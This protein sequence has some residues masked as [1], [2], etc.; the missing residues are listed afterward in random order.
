MNRRLLIFLVAIPALIVVYLAVHGLPW[1]DASEPPESQPPPR[2]GKAKPVAKGEK[3]AKALW[4]A[5]SQGRA[6]ELPRIH[7][8]LA[9]PSPKVREAAVLGLGF[10]AKQAD[11]QAVARVLE[12]DNSAAVR[13]AAVGLLLQQN[14][15][16][17]MPALVAAL[18]DE[19]ENV[20]RRAYRAICKM[21]GFSFPYNPTGP[22]AQREIEVQRFERFYPSMEDLFRRFLRRKE[23]R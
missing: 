1:S 18:R 4:H 20:R 23:N 9:D 14:K 12:K 10:Y 8:A 17:N 13:S 16:E 19:S 7:D 5:A 2:S 6:R 22:A 11:S 15:W 3:K 21:L